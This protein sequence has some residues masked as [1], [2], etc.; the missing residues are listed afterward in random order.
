[1]K[2]TDPSPGLTREERARLPEFRETL[3]ALRE[4]LKHLRVPTT[5]R[6]RR[7]I[8]IQAGCGQLCSQANHT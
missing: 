7:G 3:N 4:A 5:V 8:D 1:M 6:L 2:K